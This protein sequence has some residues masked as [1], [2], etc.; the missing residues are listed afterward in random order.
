MRTVSY[1]VATSVDGYIAARGEAMDWLRW[2]EDASQINETTWKGADTILMGR[3]T[4]DFARRGGGT[5]GT[6]K[7]YIFSRSMGKSP[8]GTKVVNDNAVAFVRSIKSG[9]GG[10]IIL[11][12][13]GELAAALIEGRVVD[14]I[15]L[16]IHPML[17][18]DGTR[19]I[20]RLPERVE[21]ELVESR[22]LQMGCLFARYR[23]RS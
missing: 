14:E 10:G 17:F 21:L 12:G 22:P 18:G 3:K 15:A 20:S 19:L 6:M 8:M 7:T 1:A 2:S 4:F 23:L 9:E 5:F 11:M 13:G 16:N